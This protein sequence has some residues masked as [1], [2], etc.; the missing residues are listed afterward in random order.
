M[1]VY[2]KER[3]MNGLKS[4]GAI[5]RMV[6]YRNE[7]RLKVVENKTLLGLSVFKNRSVSKKREPARGARETKTQLPSQSLLQEVHAI[8]VFRTHHQSGLLF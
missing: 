6:R 1:I 4:L 8:F 7:S 3:F 5:L 2:T